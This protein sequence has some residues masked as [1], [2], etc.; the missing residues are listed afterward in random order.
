MKLKVSEAWSADEHLCSEA[1]SADEHLCSEAWSADEHLCS[2]AWSADEHLCSEAWTGITLRHRCVSEPEPEPKNTC[3]QK[4][5]RE[6]S[7]RHR[8]VSEPEPEPEFLFEQ[9]KAAGAAKGAEPKR[10]SAR[11]LGGRGEHE[12]RRSEVQYK[13]CEGTGFKRR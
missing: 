12:R 8:C 11:E 10:R 2:E 13:C 1:W 6:F 5:G 7:L 3:V 4:H 9:V